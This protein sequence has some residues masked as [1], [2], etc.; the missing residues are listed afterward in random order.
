[1]TDPPQH[2]VYFQDKQSADHAATAYREFGY[3]PVFVVPDHGKTLAEMSS[4]EK[5]QVSARGQALRQL[6]TFLMLQ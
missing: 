6:R 3:D 4:A 2:Y 5:N 1:M